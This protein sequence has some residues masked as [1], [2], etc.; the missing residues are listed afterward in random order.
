MTTKVFISWS[1]DLSKKLGEVLRKWLPG[2]LQ[3]VKPYFTPEDIE[4][5]TKWDSDIAR[6][7][8]E[9][10]IGLMCLTRDNIDKAWILFEAG[11]LSKSFEKSRVC[12]ILFDL[13]ATDL[14]GPLTNFQHTRFNRE[15]FKRLVETINNAAADDKLES[16]VLESVF[17]MWWPKLEE[18][19]SEI[20][21]SHKARDPKARRPERD[22]LEEVLELTRMS[23]QRS[24]RSPRLHQGAIVELV[25]GLE[26]FFNVFMRKEPLVARE[27]MLRLR[28]PLEYICKNFGMPDTAEHFRVMLRESRLRQQFLMKEVKEEESEESGES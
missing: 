19:V 4:K 11:A 20:L 21:T 17:N 1:G 22:I 9:S 25:G 23:A 2:V 16:Q 7:L 18:Q 13:D 8:E 12:T 14:K 27:L 15:D 6:E 10:N 24:A 3:Y 26:E 5:G 28:N